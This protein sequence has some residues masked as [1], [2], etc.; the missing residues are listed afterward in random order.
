MGDLSAI[1]KPIIDELLALYTE[2]SSYIGTKPA[3]VGA[4]AAASITPADSL[5]QLSGFANFKLLGD[6]LD[7]TFKRRVTLVFGANGSGK[8]SLCESLKVLATPGQPS[9]PLENVRAA[10]AATPTFRFKFKSDAS[11]QTWTPAAGYGPRRATVKYF[12]TAIAIQSVTNAVDPRRVIIVAPFKLHVFERAKALTTTFRGTLQQVQRDNAAKLTEALQNIRTDFSKFN[13]R[14]LAIIEDRT[15]SVLM[16]QIKLG[17]DFKDQELL[18]EKRNTASEL[19]KATSEEGLKL[20]RAEHREL[21]FLLTSANSLMDATAELW[22]LE[23]ASK[24]N[25]LEKKQAAQEVLAKELIPEGSTLDGLLTLI[26]AASSICNMDAESGHA[27]PLCKRDLGA[28]EVE[29]FKQYHGLLVGELEKDITA[30][31]SDLT[32]AR[33]LV[34]VVEQID[35]NAWDK[36]KTLPDEVLT[37]AMTGAELIVASCDISKEPGAEARGAME[38]IKRLTAIWAAQVES[39]KTAIDAAANGRDQLIKQLATMHSELEPLEYAQAIADRVQKLRE[40]QQMA[41]KAQLWHSRLPSFTQVLKR[42]TETAKDA[43]ED[44]VVKDFE[45]RLDAEYLAL[46]E[47]DMAAFGV[48]LARKGADAAVTVLPQVGGKG[49]EGVLSEGEQRLHALALFFAELETCP[50]SVLVFDDPIS[51]FDYNYIAN[52][53]ARL[54]DFALKFTDRQVIVLTHNWEFFVQLQTIL[55][56]S[57]LKDDLSVQVIENCTVVADY[58]EKI[59]VLKSDINAVLTT[60]GE[61]TKAKKE[62][63]AGKMRRLIEAVVNTHVFNDQRHQFK[64]KSQQISAFYQFTKVVPLLPAEATALGDL[65][66]KLS[67]TEHDDPRTCYVNTDK[68]M[69]ENRYKAIVDVESALISRKSP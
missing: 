53:C 20:L 66:A 28:S 44:L 56:K 51:S 26:H 43:H 31:K 7:V 12:D 46:A 1:D 69:F 61:P 65:Y 29:L 67:I 27:C 40:A 15:V 55:N 37:L 36:C 39:K 9:R 25:I 63:I 64:Q 23:P 60:A 54:R 48:K 41:T 47:K 21:E 24:A 32:R 18:R 30:L 58:S 52:Y 4:A 22:A 8:S 68:A 11:P 57:V 5:E 59:D 33:E 10:S 16:T 14:P 50:Q 13:D 6:A 42:I 2:Q 49:I 45:G 17:E 19:E 62:E 38:S 34:V 35:R 3:A